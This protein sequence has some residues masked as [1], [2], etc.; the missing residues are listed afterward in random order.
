MPGKP[1]ILVIEDDDAVADVVCAMLGDCYRVVHVPDADAAI[2]AMQI[3]LPDAV[4]SDCLLPNGGLDRLLATADAAG[5]P[6]VLMSG[7]AETLAR[8]SAE[9][10]RTLQKPFRLH[11][12]LME[13]G[14]AAGARWQGVMPHVAA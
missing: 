1:T 14:I 8:L 12:L 2:A 11:Q 3:D 6:I 7:C 5:R 13:V 4:L 10:Y 9:G